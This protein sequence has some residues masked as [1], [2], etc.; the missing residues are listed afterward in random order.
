[1][2]K[3]IIALLLTVLLLTSA[4]LADGVFGGLDLFGI[5]GNKSSDSLAL[6][7]THIYGDFFA[8]NYPASWSVGPD[9][10]QD[11]EEYRYGGLLYSPEDTGFNVDI[12]LYHAAD[13]DDFSLADQDMATIEAF[14]EMT[15]ETAPN[16]HYVRREYIY[17]PGMGIPFIIYDAQDE[18][19]P[20][21]AAETIV[22]GWFVTIYGFAYTDGTFTTC[23]ELT[24]DDYALFID[25][26]NTY[27]PVP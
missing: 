17:T 6:T 12:H 10:S 13:W 4:A 9:A 11:T 25:I 18:Y 19:G 22:N 26:V 23:R 8:I 2:I 20:M 14:D 21:F 7:N 1:M 15:V 24:D 5:F 3:R 16:L 27:T